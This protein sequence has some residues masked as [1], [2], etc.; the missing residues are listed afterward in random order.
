MSFKLDR[1][2]RAM[3]R[4]NSAVVIARLGNLDD[5]LASRPDTPANHL[6]A[7]GLRDLSDELRPG[8]VDGAVDGSSL[9]P[10]IVFEDSQISR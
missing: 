6:F 5:A 9:L 2:L 3:A 7:V 4:G 10:R 1:P 8:H